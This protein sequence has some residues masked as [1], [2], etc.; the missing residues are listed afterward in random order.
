MTRHIRTDYQAVNHLGRVLYTFGD[1]P[2][3]RTWAKD[4]AHLHDGLRVER[5]TL[6]ADTVYTP[7]VVRSRP[8]FSI[9][10]WG[11]VSPVCAQ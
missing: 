4:N 1:L 8:D 11:A 7:R 10:Q 5:L 3:A 6:S 2:T 9:P